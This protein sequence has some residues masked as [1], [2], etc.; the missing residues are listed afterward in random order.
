[1]RANLAFERFCQS[2]L[3]TFLICLRENCTLFWI[4]F[5][6]SENKM[7]RSIKACDCFFDVGVYFKWKDSSY[8][9]FFS[10]FN[11]KRDVRKRSLMLTS[12]EDC[13]IACC[14]DFLKTIIKIS[15]L[16]ELQPSL[17]SNCFYSSAGFG[18][19]SYDEKSSC[20]NINFD[21]QNIEYFR[22]CC[23]KI[24]LL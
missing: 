2:C 18:S 19:G 21:D 10:F 22:F 17:V 4:L 1:M 15:G 23:Q 7:P 20:I 8:K 12:H 16:K 13:F 3:C 9:Q 24:I 5:I 6:P 14:K 11:I